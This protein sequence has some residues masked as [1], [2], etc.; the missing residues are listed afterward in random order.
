MAEDEKT[1]KSTNQES[2]LTVTGPELF[3]RICQLGI[4]RF[5]FQKEAVPR[6]PKPKKED[7]LSRLERLF[8]GGPE[9]TRLIFSPFAVALPVN[10]EETSH[11]IIFN[12][13]QMILISIFDPNHELSS[14]EYSRNFSTKHRGSISIID[15][16]IES[17]PLDPTKWS[18]TIKQRVN[19]RFSGNFTVIDPLNDDH[20]METFLEALQK[21][22][23]V[24]ETIK[25]QTEERRKKL[26]TSVALILG[27]ISPLR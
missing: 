20:S 10:L 8:N 7:T 22:I 14:E 13:G 9:T 16:I 25:V 4:G 15:K 5:Y 19:L 3:D 12:D 21:S 17:Y 1:S 23:K 6:E 24:A 26:N 27:K 11:I 18:S 2:E